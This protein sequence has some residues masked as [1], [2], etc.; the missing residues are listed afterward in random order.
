M[1]SSC[2]SP[3]S[4]FGSLVTFTSDALRP[5]AESRMLVGSFC[6]VPRSSN[7]TRFCFLRS[8]R[9]CTTSC[10]V[11]PRPSV[12]M[13]AG[14]FLKSSWV[15]ASRMRSFWVLRP[16][17]P[18]ASRRMRGNWARMYSTVRLGTPVASAI[19]AYESVG[20]AAAVG[21]D[22]AFERV[23]HLGVGPGH[24]VISVLHI[25]CVRTVDMCRVLRDVLRDRHPLD[26]ADAFGSFAVLAEVGA[27]S[28]GVEEDARCPTGP[29]GVGL[30]R[31]AHE[32]PAL[33][34]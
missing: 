14:T 6:P 34:G 19:S 25:V 7:S 21:E 4:G 23:G 27:V 20:I 8:W 24:V 18:S 33:A 30:V 3:T 28:L 13:R 16:S 12:R 26:G 2:V 29:D 9:A 1:T 10:G 11:S 32:R 5:R 17:S 22:R 31:V 15:S